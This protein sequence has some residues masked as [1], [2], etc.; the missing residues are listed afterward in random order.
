MQNE[1]ERNLLFLQFILT[2]IRSIIVIYDS[3]ELAKLLWL[4]IDNDSGLHIGIFN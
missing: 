4:S 2:E 1:G 3:Q